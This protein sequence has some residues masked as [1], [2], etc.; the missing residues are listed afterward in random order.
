MEK[1]RSPWSAPVAIQDIP[2][3]GLH[4]ELEPPEA[5]RGELAQFAGLRDLPRLTAIFDL[6][7]RGPA[8]HVRGRVSAL[9]G[10]TC[11][12]TL[13]PIES[14]IDEPLDVTFAPLP[15]GGEAG[16]AGESEMVGL[17]AEPDEEV[18]EPLVGGTIDLGALATEFLV[19]G[20]EPYPRKPGATFTPPKIEDEGAHPFAALAALKKRPGG[21]RP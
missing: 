8:V 2:E 13:E 21:G 20:I 4:L 17:H 1:I 7:R 9:V 19:L 10:Q 15:P 11:V 14:E 3:T 12:V 5:V 16:Q 6:E 18:P